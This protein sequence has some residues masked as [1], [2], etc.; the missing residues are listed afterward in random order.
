MV[1]VCVYAYVVR[2]VCGCVCVQKTA[3]VS[4]KERRRGGEAE[5]E[6]DNDERCLAKIASLMNKRVRDHVYCV[7]LTTH[8]D[9][10][11]DASV[12]EAF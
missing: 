3:R 5:E 10:V 1:Y 6:D 8:L 2:C 4:E 9:A 7:R 12:P 11:K